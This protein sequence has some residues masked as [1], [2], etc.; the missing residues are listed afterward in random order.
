MPRGARFMQR[1]RAL[2]E[3]PGNAKV[4]PEMADDNGAPVSPP[5]RKRAWRVIIA[6]AAFAAL[7]AL[8]GFVIFT[9][10]VPNAEIALRDKADG[11]VVLTGGASRVTDGLDLLAAGQGRRLLISGVHPSSSLDAIS[12]MTP[13]HRRLVECCVDLDRAAL[14]TFGNARGASSWAKAK[15]FKS[16]IVVTSN[17]HMPRAIVEFSHRMPDVALLPYPVVGE[18]W[19][20]EPWWRGGA[21]LRLLIFEYAKFLLA[22]SRAALDNMGLVPNAL[23]A[24]SESTISFWG[25]RAHGKA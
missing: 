14:N 19:R 3:S 6:A 11:I 7:A 16:L 21:A 1:W 10:H 4:P 24:F 13:E 18:K 23:R 12:R 22:S 15:G 9:F 5:A 2:N 8:I 20:N 25:P 17:Y